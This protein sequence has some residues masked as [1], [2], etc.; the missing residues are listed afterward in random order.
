MTVN[1]HEAVRTHLERVQTCVQNMDYDGVRDLIPDDGL[2]FG[3]VA[4][5][6]RGY[7]ELRSNQFEK[8]WPNI[9]EFSILEDSIS[10]RAYESV[11]WATCLFES[12]G[13][14]PN[15]LS[16]RRGRM[17]F[18]FELRDNQWVMA[19]SHDSLFPTMPGAKP[20]DA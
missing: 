6:A 4:V 8:V 17:P 11:A 5:Q 12:R 18:V 1:A 3:S 7:K 16:K 2:Y 10:I 9:S 19:H 15:D 14:D 13:S 20:S